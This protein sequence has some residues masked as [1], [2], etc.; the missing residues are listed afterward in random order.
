MA[1]LLAACTPTEIGYNAGPTDCTR[2][3]DCAGLWICVDGLCTAPAADG[4]LP[5]GD[6]TDQD[7]IDGDATDSDPIDGDEPDGDGDFDPDSDGAD[8]DEDHESC[9]LF[10]RASLVFGC[11]EPGQS[12]VLEATITNCNSPALYIGKLELHEAAIED[13]RSF[14]LEGGITIDGSSLKLDKGESHQIRIHYRPIAVGKQSAN[15]VMVSNRGEQ[16]WPVDTDCVVPNGAMSVTCDGNDMPENGDWTQVCQMPSL[17]L[18]LTGVVSVVIQNSRSAQAPLVINHMRLVDPDDPGSDDLQGFKFVEDSLPSGSP[19][20][21]V[22]IE[23]GE[24]ILFRI[25]FEPVSYGLGRAELRINHSDGTVS[26]P[27]IVRLAGETL[28]LELC[29]SCTPTAVNFGSAYVNTFYREEIIISNCGDADVDIF[30]PTIAEQQSPFAIG[31][32][33]PHHF[34]MRLEPGDTFDLSLSFF[35]TEPGTVTGTLVLPVAKV[36]SQSHDI[37]I[38]LTGTGIEPGCYWQYDRLDFGCQLV[39]TGTNRTFSITNRTPDPLLIEGFDSSNPAL[40]TVLDFPNDAVV[41]L[42]EESYTATVRF[43]PT[44]NN[45]NIHETITAQFGS[46]DCV[47]DKI[48]VY[49]CGQASVLRLSRESLDFGTHQVP[50]EDVRPQDL[51]AW[52]TTQ[53][54]FLVNDGS[55]P[56][57][58]ASLSIDGQSQETYE[59]SASQTPETIDPGQS[60]FLNVSFIPTQA[61]DFGNAYIEI[62]SDAYNRQE[63]SSPCAEPGMWTTRVPLSGTGITPEVWVSPAEGRCHFENVLIG[64][65]ET[66]LVRFANSGVGDYTIVDINTDLM[67][68]NFSVSAIRPVVSSWEENGYPVGSEN[69]MEIEINYN[70]RSLG[71]HMGGILVYHNALGATRDGGFSGSEAPAWFVLLDGTTAPAVTNRRPVALLRADGLLLGDELKVI[72]GTAVRLD[73]ILSFDHDSGDTVVEYEWRIGGSTR[74]QEIPWLETEFDEPGEVAMYFRVKDSRNL[75]STWDYIPVTVLAR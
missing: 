17:D 33:A 68:E 46:D 6:A 9:Q 37:H 52:T 47:R 41:L 26:N 19:E 38:S 64:T 24:S 11:L 4:D 53:G 34:P 39:G 16:S 7:P 27:F 23:P 5:D 54:L 18:G 13:Y 20:N 67:T 21:S 31:S 36:G 66:C 30:T 65:Y 10:S 55:L 72:E 40:F 15:L 48:D 58:V 59:L 14:E 43:T 75:Y 35:P 61:G 8:G 3:Q 22:T 74:S 42:P 2:D 29:V 63:G 57:T 71:P 51:F 50:P 73:G 28:P 69:W 60:L 1:G 44:A 12:A 62:C 49:G 70:P 25:R 56:I 45:P 32:F